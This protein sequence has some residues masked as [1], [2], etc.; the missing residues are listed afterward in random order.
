MCVAKKKKRK[1]AYEY[2]ICKAGRNIRHTCLHPSSRNFVARCFLFVL[3][4]VQSP[5]LQYLLLVSFFILQAPAVKVDSSAAVHSLLDGMCYWVRIP[6][7]FRISQVFLLLLLSLRC[8]CA[9]LARCPGQ[10]SWSGS[11]QA[12][13]YALIPADRWDNG[14][15]G[16]RD[17]SGLCRPA[18]P[19]SG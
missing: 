19:L 18:L 14:A 11:W 4:F 17:H 9:P 7:L 6:L 12:S 2:F 8:S 13:P 5:A 1:S 10:C 15:T 3:L 16:A